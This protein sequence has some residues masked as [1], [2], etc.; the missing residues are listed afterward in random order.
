MAQP[1][2]EDNLAEDSLSRLVRDFA[3]KLTANMVKQTQDY[4]THSQRAGLDDHPM[5]HSGAALVSLLAAA[6]APLTPVHLAQVPANRTGRQRSKQSDKADLWCLYRNGDLL[7]DISR[8]GLSLDGGR[9]TDTVRAAWNAALKPVSSINRKDYAWSSLGARLSLMVIHPYSHRAAF[10]AEWGPE[11]REKLVKP[12][13]KVMSKS[14][15]FL[16]TWDLPRAMQ[17]I[18][19]IPGDPESGIEFCPT[20]FIAGAF[21]EVAQE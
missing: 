4:C 5:R 16:S 19:R 18:A 21:V 6:T 2:F 12:V 10:A 20:I 8:C 15:A 3:R 9:R 17:S 11:Q 13:T 7:I 1:K 14:L